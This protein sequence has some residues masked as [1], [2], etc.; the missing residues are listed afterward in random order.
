MRGLIIKLCAVRCA[1]L[2]SALAREKNFFYVWGQILLRARE[3]GAPR[4]NNSL[5]LA[6]WIPR[7]KVVPLQC[8]N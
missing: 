7:Q 2:L 1:H 5:T 3:K 8:Q 4:F 6:F